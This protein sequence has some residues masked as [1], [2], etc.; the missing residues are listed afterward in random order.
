MDSNK[1]QNNL[2]TVTID[3]SWD[4][5]NAAAD[6]YIF[7]DMSVSGIDTITLG[8]GTITMPNV[9]I[10]NTTSGVNWDSS[11][12]SNDIK[13][14]STL[15]LTGEN[16]DIDING[17]SLMETLRGI[18]DRLNMLQPNLQLEAEW[19]ELKAAGDRY[20]ELEAKFKEKQKV[21]QALKQQG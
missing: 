19:D 13:P 15:S 11:L 14:N 5:P 21:W 17:V 10:T 18:Q 6:S 16:A 9:Y 20:R 7:S 4:R 1:D 12:W 8:S 2:D 3:L